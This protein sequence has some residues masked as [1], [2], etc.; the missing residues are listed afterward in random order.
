MT[1]VQIAFASILALTATVSGVYVGYV[2]WR[3][4]I[5]PAV[6][7]LRR[8]WTIT[9]AAWAQI[10]ADR[11]LVDHLLTQDEKR[12]RSLGRLD[13]WQPQNEV[14]P[15]RRAPDKHRRDA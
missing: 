14:K 7:W 11:M 6:G 12:L 4:L 5:A 9:V 13:G 3:N 10:V 15:Y 1:D 8:W 2:I